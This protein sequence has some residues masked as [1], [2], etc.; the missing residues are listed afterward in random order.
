MSSRTVSRPWN[1]SDDLEGDHP[2]RIVLLGFVYGPHAA[3]AEDADDPVGTDRR[4][5]VGQIGF[6]WRGGAGGIGW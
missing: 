1:A 3:F 5:V 2:V 6:V 4:R